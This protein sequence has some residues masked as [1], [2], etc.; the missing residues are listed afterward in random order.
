M[1]QVR[2]AISALEPATG[3]ESGTTGVGWKEGN[4]VIKA[5]GGPARTAR[6]IGN[7][8]SLPD[9]LA[10]GKSRAVAC[11]AWCENPEAV[12]VACRAFAT[13]EGDVRR[14]A[15]WTLS[16][17]CKQDGRL[18][19]FFDALADPDPNVRNGAEDAFKL[20][21]KLGERDTELLQRLGSDHPSTRVRAAAT[22]AL[23]EIVSH[24]EGERK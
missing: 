9:W 4:A 17:L 13:T 22:K 18:P 21:V 5:L 6:R 3:N 24:R 12:R 8:L 23:E 2:N 1:W 15:T 14:N 11:L 20:L 19:D 10:P 7:Y 16:I